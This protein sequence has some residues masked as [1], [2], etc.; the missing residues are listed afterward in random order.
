MKQE[1]TNAD[2]E[3]KCVG[4]EE[5]SPFNPL[6]VGWGEIGCRQPCLLTGPPRSA[7]SLAKEYLRQ[8][9]G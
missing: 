7:L 9:T 3:G 1:K 5:K 6:P 4:K 2:W 8:E